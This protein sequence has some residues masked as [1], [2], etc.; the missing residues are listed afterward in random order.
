[1]DEE[2]LAAKRETKR[3]DFKRSFDPDE[4]ADW[5]EIIKDLAAMANSGGGNIIVGV[6]ND[7]STPGDP[8]VPKVLAL[9]P[10][11]IS[12]KLLSYTGT[13]F[14]NFTVIE[15]AR[16]GVPVAVISVGQAVSPLVFCRPGTYVLPDGKQKTAF[17]Q[18]TIYVRHGA[19]S[20][21]AT[22]DDISK[23]IEKRLQTARK[24]WMAGV[25]KVVTAPSGARIQVLPAGVR[26]SS[27]PD[28]TPIRITDNPAAPEYRLID[29]DVTHPWR[30]KELVA[31][32]NKK[33]PEGK[34][35]NQYHVR[36][37]RTL[38]E[39]DSKAEFFHKGKFSSP[40]YSAALYEWLLQEYARDGQFFAKAA[41]EYRRRSAAE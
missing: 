32:I 15:G 12:D 8:T 16:A 23:L 25:R 24:E 41:D 26:Q 31:E 40:Q 36:A 33:L 3:I 37:L 18:G 2:I 39:I 14:D 20:E 30:Q 5:C 1:M 10:A 29:P 22:T 21:P 13:H 28:A 11:K 38:Y 4:A 19:K 6:N 9:D 17:S 34:R 7:G 27:S 35:I